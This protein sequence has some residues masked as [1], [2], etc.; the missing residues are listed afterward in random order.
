MME[1]Q[2]GHVKQRETFH[3]T[4]YSEELVFQSVVSLKVTVVRSGYDPRMESRTPTKP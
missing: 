4:D 1:N 3:V 2:I